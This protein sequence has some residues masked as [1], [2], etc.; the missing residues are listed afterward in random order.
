[1]IKAETYKVVAFN[2]N[3][4]LVENMVKSQEGSVIVAKATIQY[5]IHEVI[6][7]IDKSNRANSPAH[8][9]GGGVAATSIAAGAAG[10]ALVTAVRVEA[11]VATKPETSDVFIV[12]SEPLRLVD[13]D[14]EDI[15]LESCRKR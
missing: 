8:V 10:A 13:K 6:F 2:V 5:R 4:K 1:M 15:R 7:M 11:A 3:V 9:A 14:G 12:I